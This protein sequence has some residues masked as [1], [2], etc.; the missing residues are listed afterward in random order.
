MYRKRPFGR[1]FIQINANPPALPI[2]ITELSGKLNV[3]VLYT[4]ELLEVQYK[5]FY[6]EL[7]F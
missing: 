5:I 3:R 4:I 7:V 1:I 6:I 2:L